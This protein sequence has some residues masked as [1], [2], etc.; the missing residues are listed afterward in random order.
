MWVRKPK[1]RQNRR[2]WLGMCLQVVFLPWLGDPVRV[3]PGTVICLKCD[4]AKFKDKILV[5]SCGGEFEDIENLQWVED[6]R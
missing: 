4:K 2:A 6:S 3:E 5:C 1:P